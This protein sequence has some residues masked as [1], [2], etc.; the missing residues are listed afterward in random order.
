[1]F[2]TMYV[3]GKVV[4]RGSSETDF[5]RSEIKYKK[6][7]NGLLKSESVRPNVIMNGSNLRDAFNETSED[8][9]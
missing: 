5:E 8:E 3:V 2:L 7:G 4:K 1:M 9:V 6:V